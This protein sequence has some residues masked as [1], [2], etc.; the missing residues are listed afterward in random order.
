MTL[1]M[2][3][4]SILKASGAV[5]IENKISL[6][7]RQ[8]WNVLLSHAFDDLGTKT[9]YEIPCR[10][11]FAEKDY[12]ID[13]YDDLREHLRALVETSVQWNIYRKDKRI[14]E[15]STLLASAVVNEETGMLEYSYSDHIRQRLILP[16]SREA[17]RHTPYAKLS[18]ATQRQFR[19]K[20]TQFLYEFLVDC[21]H[22]AQAQTVTRWIHLDE[23]QSMMGTEYDRWDNIKTKL[24]V[25]PIAELTEHV[26]FSI[27][28]QS[29]K[30]MRKTTHIRFRLVRKEKK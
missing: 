3:H 28:Y 26:P 24:I 25:Q 2:T 7:Q 10:L 22:A 9:R 13:R 17:I 11:I 15:I 20:H 8:L 19:S 29:M 14:W 4:T 5:T 12:A 23:Y 30:A 18:I 1:K 27:H 16:S 6:V 21:Y